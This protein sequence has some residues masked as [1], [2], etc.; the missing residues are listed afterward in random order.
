MNN[1][2]MN[3]A[4]RA[5]ILL[6]D[7]QIEVAKTLSG[8]LTALGVKCGF[9]EDG[10]AGLARLIDD[11][12]DL[13]VVDLRMPPDRWGG[14]WLLRQ[15]TDRQ[16]LVDTLVLSG[17]AGQP[18]TIEAMRLGARD[19]VVKHNAQR[20]LADR[21]SATLAAGRQDRSAYAASQFPG[22]VALPYQRM[23]AAR[24]R[25]QRL[26]AGFRAAEAAIRFCVLAAMAV[27]R[28]S[29]SLDDALLRQLVRPSM[30]DWLDAG[31]QLGSMLGDHALRRWIRALCGK[32]ADAIVRYRN[33]TVHGGGVPAAGVERALADL[34][35]WLDFFVLAA[36]SG[37]PVNLVVP[38]VMTSDRNSYNVELAA[39]AGTT[40]SVPWTP[41]ATSARLMSG[42]V[43]LRS[44]GEYVDMW[45]LILAEAGE[46]PG[47]WSVYVMEGIQSR[48]GEIANGDKL[49][50]VDTS[51]GKRFSS[52][53]RV[54][55]D[56][57]LPSE[58][59]ADRNAGVI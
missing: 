42:H 41:T 55:G 53:E 38:G 21:V 3:A 26:L 15:L 29:A 33:E 10:E 18:E 2:A 54:V 4:R 56:L 58:S 11:V 23:A 28:S 14:L 16:L 37:V 22:P 50:Y 46:S 30:G 43:Y 32:D 40:R 27:V 31:R 59:G 47:D 39:L 34:L 12:F 8:L 35:N 19:F 13:V 57:N 1:N 9:A 36:R 44:S 7:D 17:E 49:R 20:E 45:P 25:D 24:D 5:R 52:A 6:I 51:T 48:P